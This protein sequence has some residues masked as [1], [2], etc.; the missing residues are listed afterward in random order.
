MDNRIEYLDEFY[1]GK[2]TPIMVAEVPFGNKIP[3]GQLTII[4]RETGKR[5]FS[6]RVPRD[7]DVVDDIFRTFCMVREEDREKSLFSGM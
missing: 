5:Q 2:Y 6:C 4:D 1:I 3:K 7:S